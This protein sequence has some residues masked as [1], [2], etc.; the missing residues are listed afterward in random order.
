[1]PNPK[2]GTVTND[3]SKSVK[4]IKKYDPKCVDDV[5]SC[6]ELIDFSESQKLLNRQLKSFL[7]KKIYNHSKLVVD[8]TKAKKIIK[9]LFHHY[10]KNFSFLPSYYYDAGTVSH[11]EA[12]S[13]YISGM[14]DRY[15]IN[16]YKGLTN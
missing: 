16:V 13:D 4:N 8:N 10:Q 7:R 1:M 2:L 9:F 14:T 11:E 6:P 5:R 15:A 12:I 3:I